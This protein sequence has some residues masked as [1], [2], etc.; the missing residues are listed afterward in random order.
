DAR[1]F[2]IVSET[3][4]GWARFE[5]TTPCLVTVGEKIVKMRAP[6]PEA[7][8]EAEGRPLTVRSLTELGLSAADVGLEGSLTV[9]RALR[10]D[11]PIRA[12]HIVNAGPVPERVRAAAARIRALWAG[13]QKPPAPPRTAP[14]RPPALGEVLV[15]V[16]GPEGG[17]DPETLPMA[18]EVLRLP[19]PLYPSA[20]GFGPITDQDRRGVLASG[21]VRTYWSHAPSGWRSPETL[22]ATVCE[23]LRTRTEASG[24]LFLSTSWSRELAGRV[25]ARMGLGL[26]GDAV[27]LAWEESAGLVF[28][29]PSFGGGLLAEVVSKQRPSLG[30][31]RPGS[32]APASVERPRATLDE[33]RKSLPEIKVRLSRTGSGVERDPRFGNLTSARVVVVLGMGVGGPDGVAEVVETI[34]PLEAALAATRKVVDAGWVPPQLQVGLTG[35]SVAPD[36]YLALGLSGKANHLVGAKRARVTVGINTK[37]SEPLFS[38]VDVG[39]VGDWR[40]VLGPLVRE[41]AEPEGRAL[42]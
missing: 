38:R 42:G 29:K 22:A 40:E 39:V 8:R 16:S 31:I 27:S 17:V 34:R 11:E 21:V 24:A 2:E 4:E 3:E 12:K 7:R 36:L 13:P 25:S 6:S 23:V 26:T 32:F 30:T 41:L 18:S 1:T 9:V 10:N 37:E 28:A 19:E 5:V 14:D 35:R 15:F 33:V 20:I